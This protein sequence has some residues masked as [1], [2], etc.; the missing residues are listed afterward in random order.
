MMYII[1]GNNSYMLHAEQRRVVDAFLQ[2]HGDMALER[3]DAEEV[4][5]DRIREALESMP[6]LAEQKMVVIKNP[7]ANKQFGEVAETILSTLPESTVAVLVEPKLDKRT[8]LYKFLKRQEH[9]IDCVELDQRQL[10]QWVVG[11]ATEQGARITIQDAAYLIERVGT[12][13][14]LLANEV[15]K[16]SLFNPDI[17]RDT[18]TQLTERT[19]SSTIFE[20]ID[21]AFAGNAKKALE[22]YDEQRQLRVE[23]QQL[24]AMIGWQ[25]HVLATVKM[26]GDRDAGVVAKEARLNPYVVRKSQGLARRVTIATLKQRIAVTLELDVRLKSENIDADQALQNHIIFLSE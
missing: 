25:L 26:A 2:K 7:T 11:A 15:E 21:A 8:A 18:I 4:S 3:L 16:L 6:F 5:A 19:P 22:L 14:Q 12:G 17:T 9:F 10:Q 13:Q 20:L 23:P 24:M 1:T